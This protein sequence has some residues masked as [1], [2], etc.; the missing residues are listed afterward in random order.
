MGRGV[1]EAVRSSGRKSFNSAAVSF[2]GALASM[3][4]LRSDQLESSL[5]QEFAAA[6][7]FHTS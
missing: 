6:V 5:N 4:S 3:K 1:W 2:L 7:G